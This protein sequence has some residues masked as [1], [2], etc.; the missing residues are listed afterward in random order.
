MG[1]SKKQTDTAGH[2]HITQA[3]PPN[4]NDR[5]RPGAQSLGSGHITQVPPPTNPTDGSGRNG[6]ERARQ[7]RWTQKVIY[8]FHH[9][10][11]CL[12]FF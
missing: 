10:F 12:E 2:R 1:G 3:P 7:Q 11:I 9:T 6:V 4:Q 8:S 5:D